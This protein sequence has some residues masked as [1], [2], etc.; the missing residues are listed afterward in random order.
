MIAWLVLAYCSTLAAGLWWRIGVA[1]ARYA[2]LLREQE[3]RNRH[4]I[5]EDAP[6]LRRSGRVKYAWRRDEEFCGEDYGP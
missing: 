5:R 6:P 4:E 2:E 3:E 1:E